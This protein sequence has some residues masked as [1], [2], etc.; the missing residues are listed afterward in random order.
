MDKVRGLFNEVKMELIK[1]TLIYSFLDAIMLFFLL[2][3]IISLFDIRF[4]YAL[5]GPSLISFI[6]FTANFVK[7]LRKSRLKDMEDANPELKE[8]L[9]TAHD[10][11]E[12]ENIMVQAL[13]RELKAKLKRASSGNMIDSKKIMTRVL[14]AIAIVFLIVFLSSITINLKKIEIPFDKLRFLSESVVGKTEGNVTDL[15]FNQTDVI[16]GDASIAKLGNE[17]V[18]I[19]INPTMSEIDLSKTSEAEQR[20]LTNGGI[21]QEIG[22]SSD[23]YSNQQVLEEAEA[24]V[25]YSQRIN[26]IR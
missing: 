24:A 17:I 15:V 3:F 22:I 16:Y 19:Q 4:V 23:A 12:E 21:P 1:I 20:A 11:Q 26:K 8:I 9:R 14:S 2:Y 13:F 7:R 5:A 25:N 10:S 6:F 18:N